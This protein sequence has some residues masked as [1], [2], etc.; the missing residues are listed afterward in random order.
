MIPWPSCQVGIEPATL[1][2]W[3]RLV[4][5][6]WEVSRRWRSLVSGRGAVEISGDPNLDSSERS[7]S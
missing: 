5:E 7:D 3:H 2:P 6:C 4:A 1:L